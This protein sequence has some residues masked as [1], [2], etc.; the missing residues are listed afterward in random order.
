MGSGVSSPSGRP[1]SSSSHPQSSH[2]T[3][4]HGPGKSPP[5]EVSVFILY[6]EILQY[7][8]QLNMLKFTD[9]EITKLYKLYKKLCP[10]DSDEVPVLRF[11]EFCS[12]T[13]SPLM[14]KYFQ[15]LQNSSNS[16]QNFFYFTLSIWHYCTIATHHGNRFL[17]VDS[18][19]DLAFSMLDL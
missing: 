18:L 12:L 14:T 7:K 3:T 1:S 9:S 19:S 11:L 8:E 16:F 6:P 2:L 17:S 13:D 4:G 10:K 5:I 15:L